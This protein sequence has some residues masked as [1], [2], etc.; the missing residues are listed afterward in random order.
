M[1]QISDSKKLVQKQSY[2]LALNLKLRT[3]SSRFYNLRD[4]AINVDIMESPLAINH[5]VFANNNCVKSLIS[6]T[7]RVVILTETHYKT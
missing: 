4:L 5:I 7:E 2:L 1:S 3:E 6:R